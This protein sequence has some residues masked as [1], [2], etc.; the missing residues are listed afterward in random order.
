MAVHLPPLHSVACTRGVSRE[1]RRDGFARGLSRDG[2]N[3]GVS[4]DGR[5]TKVLS[6]LKLLEGMSSP[7][8]KPSARGILLHPITAISR[9]ANQCV[10]HADVAHV[11]A[12][13]TNLPTRGQRGQKNLC[14]DVMLPPV[15]VAAAEFENLVSEIE[16]Q[17]H[18]G[19]S[20][21]RVVRK[22]ECVSEHV[23][24]RTL[25]R[26]KVLL[27]SRPAEVIVELHRTAGRAPAI[28]ASTSEKEPCENKYDFKGKD[29]KLVYKHVLDAG[30]EES[31]VDRRHVA[32][33]CRELFLT[34]E[35]QIAECHYELSVTFARAKVALSR[36]EMAAQVAKIHNSWAA[37]IHELQHDLLA[38]EEFDDH[39]D[40][41]QETNLRNKRR[42]AG[43]HNFV[44]RN[45]GNAQG[46]TQKSRVVGVHKRALQ[47]CAR[48]DACSRRRHNRQLEQYGAAVCDTP[49]VTSE[50]MLS[51][52]CLE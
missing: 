28:W 43:G 50:A 32:P 49:I 4:R 15:D 1:S 31:G 35:A 48:H 47:N 52:S 22:G 42:L 3:R 29:D 34:V 26:Y 38:R 39:V 11:L 17:L 33:K 36:K 40:G 6:G 13:T 18:G 7:K 9:R 51:S 8:E 2:V 20:S 10:A 21:V 5:R 23:P 14:D 24:A 44:R 37:R 25:R 45:I 46:C 12:H 27:P 19:D 16:E 41:L 30:D